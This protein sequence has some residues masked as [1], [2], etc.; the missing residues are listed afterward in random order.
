[1]KAL[2]QTSITISDASERYLCPVE[3][4]VCCSFAENDQCKS[5]F[6][7]HSQRL[8]T[9]PRRFNEPKPDCKQDCSLAVVGIMQICACSIALSLSWVSRVLVELPNDEICCG[10][11]LTTQDRA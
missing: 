6:P 8:F 3:Y 9:P 7:C 2:L 11:E 1:M 4:G 5:L 10:V